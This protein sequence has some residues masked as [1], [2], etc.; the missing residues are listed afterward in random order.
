MDIGKDIWVWGGE[1]K[2]A[3]AMTSYIQGLAI[4]T[5]MKFGFIGTVRGGSGLV[6]ARTP[7]GCKLF[8]QGRRRYEGR[9]EG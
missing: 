6:I 1:R 4:I 8:R 9:K 7:E 2:K 3:D 5:V